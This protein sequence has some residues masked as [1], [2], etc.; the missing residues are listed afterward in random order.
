[1]TIAS[2]GVG[3]VLDL[4]AVTAFRGVR[5]V[6]FVMFGVGVGFG[7]ASL[8]LLVISIVALAVRL[9]TPKATRERNDLSRD[10]RSTRL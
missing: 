1:M 9:L 5:T 10:L 8:I 2:F 4:L 3:V 7:F 6:G